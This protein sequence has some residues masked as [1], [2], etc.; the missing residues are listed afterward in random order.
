V[1]AAQRR[2]AITQARLIERVEASSYSSACGVNPIERAALV[3]RLCKPGMT[4]DEV[5]ETVRIVD[6]YLSGRLCAADWRLW[7]P[8]RREA[9]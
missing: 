4:D 1:I 2:S 5:D 9:D 7:L 8:G 6:V 3:K